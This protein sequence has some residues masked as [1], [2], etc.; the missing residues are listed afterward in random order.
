MLFYLV[1]IRFYMD[2]LLWLH[3]SNVQ[4]LVPFSK[5]IFEIYKNLNF[6]VFE[7]QTFLYTNEESVSV[8]SWC[9]LIKSY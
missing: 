9:I 8:I 1:L 5:F 6:D 4:F 2:L 7:K 3:N